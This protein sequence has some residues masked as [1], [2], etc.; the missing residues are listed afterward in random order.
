MTSLAFNTLKPY[1]GS[2]AP[3]DLS[4]AYLDVTALFNAHKARVTADGGIILN[5]ASC[6]SEIEFIINLG[7]WDVMASVAAPEWGI[8]R[9]GS[10]N[11]LKM[12]GLGKTPDYTSTQVGTAIHPVTLD[13]SKEIPMAVIR[14][15]G[16]GSQLVSGS[17]TLQAAASLPYI[18]SVRGLDY[19]LTDNQGIALRFNGPSWPHFYYWCVSRNDQKFQWFYSC[20]RFNPPTGAGGASASKAWDG[21]VGKSA[22]LVSSSEGQ[23]RAYDN[24]S[25]FT[26][27]SSYP[28]PNIAGIGGT[29]TLGT[30]YA[31]EQ[32]QAAAAYGGIG[33]IRIFSSGNDTA[34]AQISARA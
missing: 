19:D 13:T 25:I 1:T 12:Y 23:L 9:D 11:I 14:L 20:D 4:G 3:I 22:A 33:R 2:R 31:G 32:S 30:R 17:M 15:D 16:G 5:E 28:P 34:A 18:V 29:V 7:L 6:K 8:K 24:G 10:G 27:S 26:T 21:T